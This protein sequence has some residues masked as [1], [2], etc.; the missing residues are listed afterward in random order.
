MKL[1]S[2]ITDMAQS[3]VFRKSI[4]IFFCVIVLIPCFLPFTASAAGPVVETFEMPFQKPQLNE[5]TGYILLLCRDN[6]ASKYFVRMFN[7]SYY[8]HCNNNPQGEDDGYDFAFDSRIFISIDDASVT[9]NPIKTSTFNYASF[10][11]SY[12]SSTGYYDFLHYDYY[13]N[14][15]NLDSYTYE[16]ED[17][18]TV[19]GYQ[20][21]GNCEDVTGDLSSKLNFACIWGEELTQYNAL[22]DLL[23]MVT[24][25][26]DIDSSIL[27]MLEDVFYP[28]VDDIDY[29][30]TKLY[31]LVNQFKLQVNN[32]LTESNNLLTEIRDL[33][34]LS[35]QDSLENVD[36][37]S[38]NN[39]N[40]TSQSLLNNS[41]ASSSQSQL[42]V[43]L[44]STASN[45]IW[46]MVTNFVGLNP[47]VFGFFITLLSLGVVCLILNR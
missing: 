4:S 33:L 35:G 44:D 40:S 15:V 38:I 37:S 26:A 27:G 28:L 47:T 1:S 2:F 22:L 36:N 20:V 7:W 30:L 41:N 45:S 13:A 14:G 10:S 43:T 25:I 29:Q 42:A 11:V 18:V 19:C 8:Y 16:M 31:T 5:N 23:D 24:E 17:Y 34:S 21:F 32:K 3:S 39:H 46:G 6:S 12:A 9:F